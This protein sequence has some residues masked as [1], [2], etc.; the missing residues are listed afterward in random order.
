MVVPY[1]SRGKHNR[2]DTVR[3]K[4]NSTGQSRNQINML[5]QHRAWAQARQDVPKQASA[6][7]DLWLTGNQN[8]QQ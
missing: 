5:W 1:D 2:R 7:A 8:G 3:E 6:M 4:R